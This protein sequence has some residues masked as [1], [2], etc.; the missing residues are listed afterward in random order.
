MAPPPKRRKTDTT[1]IE[2]VTFDLADRQDYLTGF[3]KRKL[4]RTKHAKEIAEKKVSN[5]DVYRRLFPEYTTV[6]TG[7]SG[8]GD[9][10]AGAAMLARAPESIRGVFI[11]LVTASPGEPGPEPY[12]A[13]G[14]YYFSSYVDAATEAASRGLI[15]RAGLERVLRTAE[16]E[17]WAMSFADEAQ[18]A[19]RYAELD[20]ARTRALAFLDAV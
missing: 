8:Q 16:E 17:L 18:R 19:A 2:E 4:Q 11:H 13:G 1:R 14:I 10:I 15:T 3:H 9:A 6:F 5:F 12:V 20:A 7:D